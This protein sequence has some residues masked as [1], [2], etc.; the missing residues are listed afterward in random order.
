MKSLTGDNLGVRVWSKG[1]SLEAI[2]KAEVS[3]R[4]NLGVRVWSKGSSLESI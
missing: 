2:S 4:D 1:S 3:I